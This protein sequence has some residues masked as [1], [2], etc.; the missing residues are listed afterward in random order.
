MGEFGAP[1]GD[2]ALAAAAARGDRDALDL[3]LRRN[4]DR[5]HA[6]CRRILGN[7]HDALDATQEALISIAR[8]IGSFD[9]RARFSTWCYRI[10][11]NAALD[12]AR[13]RARR[14][15]P[16]PR[17][18]DRAHAS[19][20]DRVAARIDVDAALAGLPAD[21][22]AAVAL[23]DLAGLDYAEIAE[24]LGIPPGTVRSRI[25]RGRAALADLLG[26]P[27]EGARRPTR[28]TP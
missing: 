19:P 7:D 21:F 3:L 14:P 5:I 15:V 9:G 20:E 13:R 28:R 17:L 8:A 4:A 10:A 12:E 2:A 27:A 24:V 1:A 18:P 22:R 16:A 6:V 26:N 11:T 25:A 23:R